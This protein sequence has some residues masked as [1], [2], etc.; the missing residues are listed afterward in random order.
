MQLMIETIEYILEHN[1]KTN[2]P[3]SYLVCLLCMSRVVALPILRRGLNLTAG[4]CAC[5]DRRASPRN[6]A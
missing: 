3:T 4:Y 6:H 1:D 2:T 5:M